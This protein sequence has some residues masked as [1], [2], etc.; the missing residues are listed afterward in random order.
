MENVH[1]DEITS[2]QLD[3]LLDEAETLPADRPTGPTQMR[4]YI[5]VD[6]HTLRALEQRAAKTGTD[7]VDAASDALRAGVHAV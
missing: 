6:E 7:V 3:G 1:D 4:L 2:D 5:A